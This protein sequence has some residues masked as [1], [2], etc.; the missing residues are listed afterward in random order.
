MQHIR[1]IQSARGRWLPGAVVIAGTMLVSACGSSHPASTPGRAST[2]ASVSPATT[3]ATAAPSAAPST[4]VAAPTPPAA[5]ASPVTTP[6]MAVNPG[7]TK[8]ATST[9]AQMA[10][11]N[12]YL[13]ITRAEPA[14]DGAL[15]VS[16]S[17][18]K[19]VCGGPDDSH[20]N[21]A[22]TVETGH[23]TAGAS[24]EVFPVSQMREEPIKATQLNSYLK[25]DGDT[26]IF[27]VA[28]PLSAIT[29]L[30]EQFHP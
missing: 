5:S 28:G 26:R 21:V 4:A 22:K 16:A 29:S 20:Y 23:V 1:V 17:P 15:T 6:T 14:A 11:H 12:T 8:A 3:A 13:Y 25:T 27:L 19:L 24:I 2:G 30:Q 9:C 7:G 10:A 18:A